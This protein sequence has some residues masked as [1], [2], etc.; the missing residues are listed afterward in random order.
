MT[1]RSMFDP[2]QRRECF[3]SSVFLKTGSEAHTAS[4]TMGTGGPLP[5]LK[6]DRSLP[7]SAEVENE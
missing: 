2:R 4:Y 3:S 6:S 5:E 1:G 7:S